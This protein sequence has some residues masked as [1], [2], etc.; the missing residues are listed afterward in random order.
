MPQGIVPKRVGDHAAGQKTIALDAHQFPAPNE[1]PARDHQHRHRQQQH[2]GTPHRVRADFRSRKFAAQPAALYSVMR[3]H[4]TGR[5]AEQF[6]APIAGSLF[7]RWP[8]QH[9]HARRCQ[10]GRTVTSRRTPRSLRTFF[11]KQGPNGRRAKVQRH[12][13]GRGKMQRPVEN[14]DVNCQAQRSAPPQFAA[15]RGINWSQVSEPLRPF[16]NGH[17]NQSG[18]KQT[19]AADQ[20]G[21]PETDEIFCRCIAR[22][23]DED[24]EQQRAGNCAVGFFPEHPLSKPACRAACNRNLI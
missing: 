10:R 19:R 22:A 9:H 7:Q 5:H 24:G 16:E 13:R 12:V 21:R 17:Q 6:A 18:A 4:H 3:P 2:A 11:P 20:P 8:E 15:Q 23:P 14:R 1:S